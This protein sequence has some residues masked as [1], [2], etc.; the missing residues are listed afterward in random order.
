M[1]GGL[2]E[3]D[4]YTVSCG[5]VVAWVFCWMCSQHS[6]EML[7]R[8]FQYCLQAPVCHW[9]FVEFVKSVGVFCPSTPQ[10]RN[11]GHQ[12]L[13]RILRSWQIIKHLGSLRKRPLCPCLYRASV[14][15]YEVQFIA[16]VNTEVF[17]ILYCLHT[18]HPWMEIGVTGV[19]VHLILTTSSFVSFRLSSRLLCCVSRTELCSKVIS[20]ITAHFKIC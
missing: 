13:L 9:P 16:H 1:T 14:F 10:H 8:V 6:M 12:R 17:V 20:A 18:D 4:S 15:F 3:F 5:F 19:L 2:L 11:T 7:W